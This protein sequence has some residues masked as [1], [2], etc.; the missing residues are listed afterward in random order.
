[1]RGRLYA[2]S[3]NFP[4]LPKYKYS[5]NQKIHDLNISTPL[6]NKS[7][8]SKIGRH[9]LTP[10]NNH[11]LPDKIKSGSNFSLEKINSSIL[12]YNEPM[13]ATKNP[14]LR[15]FNREVGSFKL[16]TLKKRESN[17]E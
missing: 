2:D 4:Q 13:S 9:G 5:F 3:N 1:M 17:P 14:K 6:E 11:T 12:D 10:H 8:F 7:M 15:R 16:P